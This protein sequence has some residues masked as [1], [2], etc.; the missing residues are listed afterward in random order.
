MIEE[1]LDVKKKTAQSLFDCI[2]N[3]MIKDKVQV[4][5]HPYRLRNLKRASSRGGCFHRRTM[6][7]VPK[8]DQDQLLKN[9]FFDSKDV[10]AVTDEIAIQL[11]TLAIDKKQTFELY[12]ENELLKEKMV[13]EDRAKI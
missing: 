13:E 1:I 9:H 3:P 10:V 5:M 4:T 2:E 6:G 11:K 7:P 8:H 12:Q